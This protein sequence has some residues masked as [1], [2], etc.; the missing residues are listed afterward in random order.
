VASTAGGFTNWRVGGEFF[1]EYRFSQVFGIN[2]TIDY[3][4]EISDTQLPAGQAPGA[5]PGTLG[6][7]DLNYRRFQAFL[8]ARYFY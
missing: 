2:T 3:V 5:A 1:A 8:G 6:V 7:Y 4:Q